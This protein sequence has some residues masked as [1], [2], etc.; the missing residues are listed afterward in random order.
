MQKFKNEILAPCGNMESF[1]AAIEAG[2]D[3]VYLAGKMFGARAFSNN[4]TNDELEFIIKYAHKYGVRVYVTCNILIYESEVEK[5][6]EFVEFLHKNNV[7]ALIMQDLGMIDLVHKTF[8]NLELHG[9]TQMHIHNLDGARVAEG[10]GLKRVVLARETPLD[11]IV[12]I[13]EKTN[14][15]IEVFVH[16]ALCASYSGMCLFASSIG[17]RSGNRGTCSGCCRLPY[18]VLDKDLNILNQGKY[19]LSMKDL[20]TIDELDKL[21]DAGI[22]SF[23]IEGRM[24]SKEYVYTSVLMYKE[25]R[26]NY[27]N[28]GKLIVNRDYLYKLNNIFTRNYT[29]GFIFNCNDVV[30]DMSPNHMGILVGKVIKSQN[31]YIEIKLNDEVS[32]HDGLRIVNKNFEYGFN[33]NEFKIK[34]KQVYLANKNDIISLKVKKDV[35]AESL[36]YRT[37]SK[38]IEEEISEIINKHL[39][40][41]PI[42]FNLKIKKDESIKLIV[43]DGY[44]ELEIL[45]KAPDIAIN[46]SI[47]K[48][49]IE[50]KLSKINNTIYKTT[51]ITIELD[52]NI[53]VPISEINHLKQDILE[54]LDEKRIENFKKEFKKEKYSIMVLDFE[55][56]REY[57]ILT[58]NKNKIVKKYSVI[59]SDTLDNSI[60]KIPKVMDNYNNYLEDK[61]Y[62][63]GEIGSLNKLKN[64]VT[65]YSF[66]VTN[67]YT[68]A[69][70]HSL[71]VKRVTLSLELNDKE[72]ENLIKSYKKRLHKN[73]NLEL[74]KRTTKEL[75]VLK[76]NLN[77]YGNA[78]Y[79]KDRFNNKYKIVKKGNFFYIYDYKETK[80]EK[81]DD[82]YFNL[83]IN[84]LRDEY[85][86]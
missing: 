7:D 77:K 42:T 69:F 10:L 14:L 58:N 55:R 60:R 49:E 62:L 2:C 72:I 52:D 22:D 80:K 54:M 74:I 21:I 20:K 86:N 29:N 8:P 39:R 66:N 47:T 67:S 64:V 83:G 65:D 43:N 28:T 45:G 36:V 82:Y 32:I 11:V 16:G 30:N 9:S 24:K 48:E 53:F 35:P 17:P 25:A 70:L 13:K 56:K 61:E 1:Y 51:N 57:S 18:D 15:E 4:F 40:K 3:A 37:F 68:V 34:N 12:E 26:D 85:T 33:L 6:L 76:L 5:F 23:K 31:N 38:T 44:N 59:Y 84:Y 46:K 78:L 75:M 50:T 81:D 73:P 71:G 41:I 63:V 19:P 27:L 79:L